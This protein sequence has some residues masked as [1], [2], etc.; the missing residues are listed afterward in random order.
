MAYDTWSWDR[1][2][3]S[4]GPTD[5]EIVRH[6]PILRQQSEAGYMSTRPENVHGIWIFRISFA[7]IYPWCYIYLVNWH[8]SH[9]GGIPFYIQWPFSMAGIPEEAM[10]AAPGGL[11]PWDSEIEP[12]AGDGP[13]FLMYWDQDDFPIKRLRTVDN[14]W[15]TSGTIE[16]RQC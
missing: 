11:N 7:V 9:R 6:D 15:T 4:G 12:G 3:G 13:T 1:T 10:I 16:L 5:L 14:Y 8:N 2:D